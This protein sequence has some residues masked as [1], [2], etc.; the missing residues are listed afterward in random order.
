MTLARAARLRREE[1]P[2]AA[3]SRNSTKVRD[4]AKAQG[5]T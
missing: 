5:L 1:V 2:E 4:W 3:G